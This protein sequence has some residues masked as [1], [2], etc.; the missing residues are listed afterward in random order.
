MYLIDESRIER[1][2]EDDLFFYHDPKEGYAYF[3]CEGHSDQTFEEM[4][5]PNSWRKSIVKLE[6]G[7]IWWMGEVN[8]CPACI[9]K[10][11]V[12]KA[13]FEMMTANID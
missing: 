8:M 5:E 6:V 4:Q 13:F 10:N 3:L 2:E 12:V 7:Q 9:A 11:P 1:V